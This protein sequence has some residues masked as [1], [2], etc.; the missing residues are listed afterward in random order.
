MHM[1]YVTACGDEL[2][3]CL[4]CG[5]LVA[6]NARHAAWHAAR[7]LNVRSDSTQGEP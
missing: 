7:T 6:N 2:H 3:E 5:A 1:Q 4:E